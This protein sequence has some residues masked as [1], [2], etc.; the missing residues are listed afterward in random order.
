MKRCS[1]TISIY[2]FER[3]EKALIVEHFKCVED[4]REHV[5]STSP[6]TMA[7]G[8]LLFIGSAELATARRE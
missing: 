2:K 5:A 8:S 7:N 6:S 1:V 3:G 4:S